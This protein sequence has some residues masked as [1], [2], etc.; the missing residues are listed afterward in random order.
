[1]ILAEYWG[2]F[3]ACLFPF[4]CAGLE[5]PLTDMLEQLVRVWEVVR[6]EEHVRSPYEQRLGRQEH[7]RRSVA[8]AFV[9]KAVYNLTTTQALIDLLKSN[10]SL[11]R[12]CGFERMSDVPSAATFSRSFGEFAKAGLGDL[13]HEALVVRHIG[14]Q[15]VMH[16]SRDSTAVSARERAA[17]KHRPLQAPKPRRGRP[18]KGEERACAEPKR[19]DVQLDQSAVQGLCDLPKVCDCG[20]KR[21]T[22]GHKHTWKGWKAHIDWSDGAVPIAVVTTSASV[23]DSQAAIPM[24]KLT[25]QRVTSLYDLMDSAYDAPQ[26]RQLSKRLGHVALIDANPR[27]SGVPEHKLFDSAMKQ[28]Y[29]QRTTAERGNS[30]LK[31]EFGLRHLRVRGHAKAHLH[32]MFGVIA[33]FAD[34]L[35][36]PF[37]G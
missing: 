37:T 24:M 5:E 11:R 4:L 21:D 35:L 20:T 1:L 3:Q 12:L 30:R 26:I 19:L 10:R 6:I 2:R 29:K 33:L 13:V 8:R 23:H 27:R 34:Q 36:K 15:V 28:R 9:A 17:R 31:D 14:E 16:V 18:K 22:G 25:A 32:I 7:D